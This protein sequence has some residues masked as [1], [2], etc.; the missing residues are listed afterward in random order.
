LQKSTYPA[1]LGVEGAV[2]RA[3]ALVDEA[4][5]ALDRE[6][7]LTPALAALARFAVSRPS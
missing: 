5:D 7:L 4:C 1:L 6:H 3:T 2:A